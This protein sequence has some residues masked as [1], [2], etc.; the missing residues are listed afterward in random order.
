MRICPCGKQHNRRGK[1]GLCSTCYNRE[2]LAA[3]IERQEK[4]NERQREWHKKNPEKN[5]QYAQKYL[6]K[7]H[8]YVPEELKNARQA[9]RRLEQAC[10]MAK[11]A[12]SDG[13]CETG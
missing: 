4:K 2:Y 5:L 1:A 3:S 7:I 8:F 6:T 13:I 11:A 9:I 10:A 12:K